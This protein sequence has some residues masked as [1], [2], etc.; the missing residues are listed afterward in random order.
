MPDTDHYQHYRQAMK[1]YL[2]YMMLLSQL[3]RTCGIEVTAQGGMIITS[4]RWMSL[5]ACANYQR[6]AKAIARLRHAH[7]VLYPPSV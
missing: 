7:S 3:F 2:R 1:P 4:P 5:E 6:A